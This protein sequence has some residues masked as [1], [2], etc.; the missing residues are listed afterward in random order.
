MK[1]K[2]WVWVALW[3]GGF[4]FAGCGDDS[5]TPGQ[6]YGDAEC[7]RDDDC[8]DGVCED[9]VCV[10]DETGEATGKEGEA[11]SEKAK[12]AK[13]LVCKEKRCVSKTSESSKD[14]QGGLNQACREDGSCD[15]GLECKSG[16]CENASSPE[17]AG[18][19][20]QA[21]REDGS[22]DTGLECKSGLCEN[23][24]LPEQAGGLN[25][26]CRADGS[27][28]TGLECKSGLCVN[29][30]LP[31]QAGGLNQ[32]CRA[33][34]SC[35]TGL[36]CKGGVCESVSAGGNDDRGQEGFQCRADNS[37]DAGLQCFEGICQINNIPVGKKGGLCGENGACDAGLR[38]EFYYCIDASTPS[39]EDAG[40]L[41]GRCYD[42]QCNPGLKC[43]DNDTCIK[44]PDDERTIEDRIQSFCEIQ[45]LCN[46]LGVNLGDCV[47]EHTKQYALHQDCAET[48]INA[49]NCF[50]NAASSCKQYSPDLSCW[51][52]VSGK[53]IWEYSMYTTCTMRQ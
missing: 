51:S 7:V 2:A 31:E 28:D 44:I 13:G 8:D 45:V 18:G 52:G 19:L 25:Q 37:C 39:L 40:I 47:R 12:C 49:F 20:N 27:C 5:Q 22:C 32:A 50:E 26:A 43:N 48:L 23:A 9:G 14:A 33:D 38:C 24:S 16:L 30:S 41:N 46:G 11:C 35:D 34:G 42:K 6:N 36:E 17:Q 29:A 15:T 21:C 1:K 3:L 10:A 53:C 4:G